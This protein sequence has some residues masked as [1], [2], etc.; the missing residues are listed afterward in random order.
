MKNQSKI[1]ALLVVLSVIGFTSRSWA[2]K[3]IAEM[4]GTAESST[5]KGTIHLEDT[6]DGL[7]VS[8][9]FIG[10]PPGLHAFHI[11]EFGDCSE[12]GKAAGSHYNP[13]HMPHGNVLKDGDHKAHVGDMGNITASA[14]GEATLEVT[15]H[16]VSLADGKYTVG[17]RAIILHEKVD[18]FSQ[19]TG[20]AGGR[21][22][23]GTIVVTGN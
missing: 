3:G 23:C 14:T 21:I 4:K 13:M 2:A 5:L 1:A 7:K 22:G 15:L 6:P 17:G 19:P 12:M 16:D 18:D 20:N 10:V 9:Q 8:A 11:H